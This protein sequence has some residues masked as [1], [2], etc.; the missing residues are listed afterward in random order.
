VPEPAAGGVLIE[1]HY[2]CISPGTEMRCLAGTQAGAPA[3]PFIPGYAMSGI[4]IAAGAGAHLKPGARVF[5][6]GTER[7]SSNRNWGGHIGH[8]VRNAHSVF[9]VPDN[10]DLCEASLVK[11]AAIAYHGARQT[12]PMAHERV[13]A[14]GLG[15]IGM[16]AARMHAL[17]GARVMCGDVSAQRIALARKA[18]LDAV[19]V[20]G[21]LQAAFKPA[22]P[23]GADIVIDSTGAPAVLAKAVELGK[24]CGWTDDLHEP[25]RLL[26]Q[27]SYAGNFTLPYHE[28][29]M[30]EMKILLTRDQQPRDVAAV[31]D[32]LHR[33]KLSM[34]D[35]VSEVRR[36]EDAAR[37]YAELQTSRDVM[38]FVFKW[39]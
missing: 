19:L 21:D 31:L 14:V 37:T 7:A 27:G 29:F 25:A 4:V 9:V 26:V 23:E 16:L 32:L 18:G 5:C 36:P 15:P 6:S 2:S 12:Q 10:V 1:T 24:Q 34:I 11:M 13:A 3:W 30:R 39:N 22:F 8:A 17:S 35:L 33:C 28:A 38:T 20:D